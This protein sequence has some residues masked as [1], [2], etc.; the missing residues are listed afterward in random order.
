MA[1]NPICTLAHAVQGKKTLSQILTELELSRQ[2]QSTPPLEHTMEGQGFNRRR[3]KRDFRPAFEI[4]LQVCFRYGTRAT[5]LTSMTQGKVLRVSFTL[6][7]ATT[8]TTAAATTDFFSIFFDYSLF[9]Q[10][11]TG[12]VLTAFSGKGPLFQV[13]PLS[14][15]KQE[16]RESL[17]WI[18]TK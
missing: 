9:A 14:L 18:C 8:T 17:L 3:R 7:A 6:P 5:I 11:R 4:S 1:L 13:F 12:L 16:N 2:K 10:P 15:D